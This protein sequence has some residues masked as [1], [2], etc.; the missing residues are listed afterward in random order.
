MEFPR[1]LWGGGQLNY[2]Q[3]GLRPEGITGFWGR[4]WKI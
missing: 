1:E 3:S 2:A 4:V